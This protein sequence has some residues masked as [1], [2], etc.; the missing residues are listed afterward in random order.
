MFSRYFW[1][2]DWS[3][4]SSAGEQDVIKSTQHCF[5]LS[6][7]GWPA[8]G[9]QGPLLARAR[10]G[11]VGVLLLFAWSRESFDPQMEAKFFWTQGKSWV[12]RIFLKTETSVCVFVVVCWLLCFYITNF[13]HP[14]LQSQRPGNGPEWSWV[15]VKSSDFMICHCVH[16]AVVM[17]LIYSLVGVR[18][19]PWPLMLALRVSDVCPL[20]HVTGAVPPRPHPHHPPTMC[21]GQC[22][23]ERIWGLNFTSRWVICKN[24]FT[25]SY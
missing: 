22:S 3:L 24:H 5:L 6:G 4:S 14:F 17:L 18:R 12:G 1:R 16:W 8:D 13:N 2:Q 19:A 10:P 21:S 20:P 7:Q 15:T 25:P 23:I 11:H 9:R